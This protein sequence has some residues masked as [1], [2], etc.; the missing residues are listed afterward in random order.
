MTLA[1]MITVAKPSID[2]TYTC[3]TPYTCPRVF[4][5]W[6]K[7][8][9]AA[10]VDTVKEFVNPLTAADENTRMAIKG[11]VLCIAATASS[12]VDAVSPISV[13]VRVSRRPKASERTP[14][15][16]SMRNWATCSMPS[17]I[18]INNC[19]SLATSHR[20]LQYLDP[21]Q[22]R[23]FRSKSSGVAVVHFIVVRKNTKYSNRRHVAMKF[24]RAIGTIKV[25]NSLTTSIM[26]TFTSSSLCMG[27]WIPCRQPL[28]GDERFLLT[29][30][31]EYLLLAFNS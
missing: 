22:S 8:A 19:A 20:S 9:T 28:E 2:N 3:R 24:S 16:G 21:L 4:V 11:P 5:S 27:A 29:D 18:P 15:K 7:S 12:A 30:A 13:M 14:R 10:F 26:D 6:N 25:L 31:L 17:D 1:V 23:E